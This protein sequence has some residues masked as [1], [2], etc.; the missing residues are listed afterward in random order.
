MTKKSII[1]SINEFVN[2]NKLKWVEHNHYQ[3][4]NPEQTTKTSVWL[5]EDDYVLQDFEY[6][7]ETP[8]F[9]PFTKQQLLLMFDRIQELGEVFAISIDTFGEMAEVPYFCIKGMNNGFW[10]YDYSTLAQDVLDNPEN[11]GLI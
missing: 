6:Q 11:Y 8:D 9:S 2:S 7:I 4:S 3:S 10:Y 5:E 1:A